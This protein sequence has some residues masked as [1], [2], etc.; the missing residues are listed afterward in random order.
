MF[1]EKFHRCLL[2]TDFFSYYNCRE[3]TGMEF[4]FQAAKFSDR[5]RS[6]DEMDV[7]VPSFSLSLCATVRDRIGICDVC[8]FAL[9][10]F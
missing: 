4:V 6:R 8:Q 3:A 9:C 10:S 2:K 7:Q 5:R 1:R